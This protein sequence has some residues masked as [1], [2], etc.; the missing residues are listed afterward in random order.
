MI[1]PSPVHSPGARVTCRC[2]TSRS[3]GRECRR[4]RRAHHRPQPVECLAGF[5][6]C[7]SRHRRPPRRQPRFGFFPS[8]RPFSRALG[9]PRCRGRL[10]VPR[11][12]GHQFAFQFPIPSRSVPKPTGR[13][14]RRVP[15]RS[16]RVRITSVGVRLSSTSR[17]AMRSDPVEPGIIPFGGRHAPH[18]SW[19]FQLFVRC[20]WANWWTGRGGL[21]RFPAG[22]VEQLDV[23]PS[24]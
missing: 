7:Q 2:R 22:G 17:R 9:N 18:T 13:G 3:P 12:S 11:E 20:C 1:A 21:S 19:P 10:V 6:R 8:D 4:C 14:P 5:H 16:Q 24:R 23:E 15:P